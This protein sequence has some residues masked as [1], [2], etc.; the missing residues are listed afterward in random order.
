MAAMPALATTPRPG[1]PRGCGPAPPIGRYYFLDL[2]PGRSF[3]E[4]AV[5][6]GLQLFVLSW[7]NPAAEQSGW[8]LDS[9]AGCVLSA[10]DTVREIT[11]STDVDLMGFCAGGIIATIVLNHLAARRRSGPQHVVRGH[12]A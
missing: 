8:D 6:R 7:R 1:G 10:I 5:N 9:Y 12:A 4:Y 3:A 2:A 11:G